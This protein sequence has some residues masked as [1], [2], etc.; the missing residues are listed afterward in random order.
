MIKSRRVNKYMVY[1]P[2]KDKPTMYYADF[3]SALTAAKDINDKCGADILVL[4]VVANVESEKIK[5]SVNEMFSSDDGIDE[6]KRY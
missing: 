2:R 1:N 4:K 5:I 3:N 6:I